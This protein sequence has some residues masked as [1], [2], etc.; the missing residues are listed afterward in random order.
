[1][2]NDYKSIPCSS[3]L[4][5][6][7]L[8]QSLI[9]TNDMWLGRYAKTKKLCTTEREA[10]IFVDTLLIKAGKQPINILKPKEHG[11]I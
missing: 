11:P 6:V 2:I 7:T 1:M 4:Q 5:G 10:G 8:A 9:Q 3:T